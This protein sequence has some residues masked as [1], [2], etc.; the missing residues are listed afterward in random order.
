MKIGIITFHCAY[1]YGSVLQAFALK[2]YLERQGNAVHVIDYH[3]PNFDQY[4]LLHPTNIRHLCSDILFFS[5]NVRRKIA[6]ETFQKRHLNLTR[7]FEGSDAEREISRIAGSFDAVICGS[8]QIWNLDCT[9]GLDGCY[10]LRFAPD[11]VRKIAYA[12]SLSQTQFQPRFFD[13]QTK[14][15]LSR[16]LGRFHAISVRER[17]TVPVYQ[18]LTDKPIR[19]AID[20]TLL[21][22]AS[23]YRGIA[24]HLPKGLIND[25]FV[26]AYTLWPNQRMIEYIDRIAQISGLP[27]VYSSK[28]PIHYRSRSINCYGMSPDLFLTLIDKARF[29]VSNSFH[30]TVFS[31]LFHKAFITF[32][33][34]KSTSRMS[35]LLSQLGIQDHI[36]IDSYEG[37]SLP[38]GA[39]YDAVDG[40]LSKMKQDSERFLFDALS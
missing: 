4:K 11:S 14:D 19:V 38:V 27:I 9:Q 26:F 12:P 29:V 3:S 21:L 30:A 10:F 23:A 6:F 34:D 33:K 24:A 17:S 2:T 7:R 40:L 35:D 13:D 22:D 1:N 36:V 25:G 37:D 31:V 32:G 39:N 18:E 20:P 5:R 15:E 28:I 8:D 16:L